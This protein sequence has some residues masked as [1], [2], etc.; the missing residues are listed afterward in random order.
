MQ[1]LQGALGRVKLSDYPDYPCHRFDLAGKVVAGGLTHQT[2]S[3]VGTSVEN[4]RDACVNAKYF[5]K[6]W[7]NKKRWEHWENWEHSDKHIHGPASC[8]AFSKPKKWDMARSRI[9]H[10]IQKS[11]TGPYPCIQHNLREPGT[12]CPWR[13]LGVENTLE[14]Y[15]PSF[16]KAGVGRSAT[17]E[18]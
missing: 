3:M 17:N 15:G 14:P 9:P 10:M 2:N 13:A 6:T 12:S 7:E 1:G 11:L 16:A 8:L 18:T 5:C 4:R